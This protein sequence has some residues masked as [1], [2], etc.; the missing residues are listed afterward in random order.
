MR[1]SSNGESEFAVRRGNCVRLSFVT[2]HKMKVLVVGSERAAL[3]PE[4][5]ASIHRAGALLG[6]SLAKRGHT[7]LVG[8]DDP[9]DVDPDVVRGAL[10]SDGDAK[11]EVHLMAGAELCYQKLGAKNVVN[12]FHRYADWDVTILEVLRQSADA[13]VAIGGKTGVVQAGV[14]GWMLG[15]P[16]LPLASFGGGGRT[17][18][19]YGSGVRREFYFDALSDAEID[20]LLGPWSEHQDASADSLVQ[21]MERIHARAL[22]AKRARQG[23][24]IVSALVL[25]MLALWVSMLCAPLAIAALEQ[26]RHEPI[27]DLGA[28]SSL[29]FVVLLVSVCTA[30]AVGALMQTLRGLRD[31]REISAR[32][33]IIDFV[34]GIV[35]GFLSA[36][37]YLLAQ[38]AVNG[39]VEMPAT[40]EDFV[41]V[42]LVVGL[43]ALFSSLY[44]DAALARFDGLKE[45]VLA[46]RFAAPTDDKRA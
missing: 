25:A 29:R 13:V 19:G 40:D 6:A 18:W 35:A 27:V 24:L 30:G 37:L 7:I 3:T 20:G 22:L 16:V 43:A 39:R 38:A 8:S 12:L 9:T 4:E 1:S 21:A 44:L 31:N 41:R 14:A 5:K 23:F 10:E 45:S 33:V 26:V 15:R 32:L 46:G 28:K 42:A 34:L 2:D 36:C 11:I 17:V